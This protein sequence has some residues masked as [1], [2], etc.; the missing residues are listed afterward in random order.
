MDADLL[1]RPP[2]RVKLLVGIRRYDNLLHGLFAGRELHV[3][4]VEPD[5]LGI[6]VLT[7]TGKYVSLH[8]SEFI[9]TLFAPQS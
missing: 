4:R 1:T 5:G 3:S 9:V 8:P 7:D 6:G 2:V